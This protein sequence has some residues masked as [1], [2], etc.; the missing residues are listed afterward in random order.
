M[1]QKVIQ[2]VQSSIFSAFMMAN[3][4]NDL[5]DLAKLENQAFLLNNEYINLV[6]TVSEAFQIVMF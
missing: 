6:D 4:I 2:L 1:K 3:L 5:L